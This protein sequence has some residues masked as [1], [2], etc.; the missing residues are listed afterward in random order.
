MSLVL[1]PRASPCDR[2]TIWAGAFQ[3]IQ[4]PGGLTWQ[5]NGIDT[6][7]SVVR[8]MSSVRPTPV[9]DPNAPRVFSGVYEF[10]GLKSD[11]VY[12]VSLTTDEDHTSTKIRTLPEHIPSSV[13]DSFNLLLVSCFHQAED[14]GGMA[15]TIVSQLKASSKPHLT[16]LM[17]DQVYLDLPTLRNF[18][19]DVAWLADKFERDYA[20]NWEKPPG[21]AQVLSAAPSA[22]L[23]DD[24]EYWNNFPHVSPIIQNSWTK[25]GRA[26]WKQ[27]ADMMY[28]GFQ[29]WSVG[30]GD[31]Y[32]LNIEPLSFFLADG[33]SRRDFKRGSM[34]TAA[35]MGQL[36]QWVDDVIRQRRVGVFVTGQ[37]LFE[38]AKGT[39]QGK[40]ADYAMADYSDYAPLI[41]TLARLA[42]NGRPLL[43]LTGDVHWGRVVASRDLGSQRNAMYEIISSP[44]SLVTTIGADSL[45]EIGA[46]IG[47]SIGNRN[48]WPRHSDPEPPPEYLA[49]DVLSKAFQ[50]QSVH[51]QK[52]NHVTLVSF[53]RDGTGLSMRITYWPVDPNGRETAPVQLPDIKIPGS[54][55]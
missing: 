21:Y 46:I 54:L 28:E 17:G 26:R 47:G 13:G 34:M 14:R 22:S 41:R 38:D 20:Q 32:V 30:L 18:D 6:T 2:L 16:L 31:P 4:V 15:G 37:S 5:L 51:A 9:V 45:K 44:A 8:P 49:H 11:T 12:E 40:V 52:G 25:E 35:A 42:E 39:L 55:I 23:P 19:D 43:C 50:C 1:Y 3:K 27:A 7:P 33:R 24:H 29:S 10:V 36:K 48:P 53:T